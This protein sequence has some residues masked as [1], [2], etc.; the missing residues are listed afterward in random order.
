MHSPRV[1]TSVFVSLIHEWLI[2]WLC[3]PPKQPQPHPEKRTNL[4]IF[5]KS[6]SLKRRCYLSRFVG[7][8]P[9]VLV[10]TR[11]PPTNVKCVAMFP[12]ARIRWALALVACVVVT[13]VLLS[14]RPFTL[15]TRF[16][17]IGNRK[18]DVARGNLTH[19]TE[20]TPF[21]VEIATVGWGVNNV[22]RVISVREHFCSWGGWLHLFKQANNYCIKC[23]HITGGG[24]HASWCLN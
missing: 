1:V 24:Y 14:N 19:Y 12:I 8:I 23:C 6:A 11:I 10:A 5:Q 22:A 13:A 21:C 7:W 20:K 2:A 15:D 9:A 18:Y 4:L 17:K 16:V 3:A